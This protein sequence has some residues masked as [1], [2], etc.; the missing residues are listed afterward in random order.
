MDKTEVLILEVEKNPVLFDKAEKT[1]KETVKKKDIWKGIGE[2]VGLTDNSWS[3]VSPSA[4]RMFSGTTIH[5]VCII[6]VVVY[7]ETNLA[8][9][10]EQMKTTAL[11]EVPEQ[12]ELKNQ[13][14]EGEDIKPPPPTD[15]PVTPSIPDS[16]LQKLGLKVGKDPINK[17]SSLNACAYRHSTVT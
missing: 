10:R 16:F 12:K 1:Y 7:L 2:K 11:P 3:L 13:N 9:K 4:S 5:T 8:K 17:E 14:G 15:D 6:F